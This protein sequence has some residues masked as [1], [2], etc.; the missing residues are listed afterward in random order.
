LIKLIKR[1]KDKENLRKIK[2][3]VL[4]SLRLAHLKWNTDQKLLL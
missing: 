2:K 3:M 4:Q 1:R